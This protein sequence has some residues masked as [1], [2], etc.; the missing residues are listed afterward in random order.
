MKLIR[1][2]AYGG[3]L[4]AACTGI[5]IFA[6]AN[7]CSD[8]D[9]LVDSS[10]PKMNTFVGYISLNVVD[11]EGR[12]F[13]GIPVVMELHNTDDP[14]TVPYDTVYTNAYGVAFLDKRVFCRRRTSTGW[15]TINIDGE[16][17]ALER[18]FI[19][20]EQFYLVYRILRNRPIDQRASLGNDI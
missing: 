14:T 9:K 17:N 20:G 6:F 15:L 8:E 2:A 12:P 1:F 11:S 16:A 18:Q 4:F 5:F 7:G 10:L 13:P 19:N 3:I